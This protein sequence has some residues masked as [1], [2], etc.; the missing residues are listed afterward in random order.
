MKQLSP[1]LRRKVLIIRTTIFEPLLVE[2]FV[3]F[4]KRRR[5]GLVCHNSGEEDF[6][7]VWDCRERVGEGGCGGKIRCHSLHRNT[8]KCF[9][10]GE[11]DVSLACYKLLNEPKKLGWLKL[12]APKKLKV[13][14]WNVCMCRQ[15]FRKM[16]H[17][18]LLYS[19]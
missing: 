13:M 7:L 19:R 6:R 9:F 11:R 2:L 18:L 14:V 12:Q 1:P 5:F 17:F 8:C 15:K 4:V 10:V 16:P 3:F